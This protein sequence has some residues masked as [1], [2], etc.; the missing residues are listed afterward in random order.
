[1]GLLDEPV[2]ALRRDGSP[3]QVASLA[4]MVYRVTF[5]TLRAHLAAG[6]RPAKG[7][8]TE[9][10]SFCLRGVQV[11]APVEGGESR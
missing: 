1:M 11:P 3:E 9:L 7:E 4:S 10:V 8:V 5:A 2:R 6:T